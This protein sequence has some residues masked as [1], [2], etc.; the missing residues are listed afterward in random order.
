M[1]RGLVA[2]VCLLTLTACAASAGTL[3]YAGT[4]TLMP[5]LLKQVKSSQQLN[6]G[7]LC[8][9]ASVQGVDVTTQQ[10]LDVY[11]NHSTGSD[12]Q[13]DKQAVHDYIVKL[14]AADLPKGTS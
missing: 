10:W 7:Q 2:A 5:A 3:D 12:V 6:T 11:R 4:T 9:G 1:I 14:C 8:Y 13:P